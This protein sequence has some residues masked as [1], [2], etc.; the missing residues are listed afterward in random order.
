MRFHISLPLLT[1]LAPPFPSPRSP[2]KLTLMLFPSVPPFPPN[3]LP[4][5]CKYVCVF[6][7]FLTHHYPPSPFSISH[8]FLSP[9][10]T[11]SGSKY[12]RIL[13]FLLHLI[14]LITLSWILLPWFSFFLL[15]ALSQAPLFCINSVLKFLKPGS[16]PCLLRVQFLF[17]LRP[18][19]TDPPPRL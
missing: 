17:S 12:S 16:K 13:S 19:L 14:L 8:S 18:R 10:Q 5:R 1:Q 7:H 3:S 6:L 9:L 4:T 11:T 15:G 2:R